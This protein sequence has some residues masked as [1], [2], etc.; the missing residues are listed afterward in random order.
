MH[1]NFLF[2]TIFVQGI[3]TPIIISVPDLLTPGVVTIISKTMSYNS[4]WLCLV[5]F[6][7]KYYIFNTERMWANPS[8]YPDAKKKREKNWRGLILTELPGKCPILEF[9]LTSHCR[10]TVSLFAAYLTPACVRKRRPWSIVP[11]KRRSFLWRAEVRGS[12][13]FDAGE[14]YIYIPREKIS[15]SGI[16]TTNNTIICLSQTKQITGQLFALLSFL[17]SI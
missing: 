15:L 1:M 13:T 14:E 9:L 5:K 11:K 7:F 10:H 3:L 6:C 2:T 4:R 8:K 16:Y 17:L 12:A